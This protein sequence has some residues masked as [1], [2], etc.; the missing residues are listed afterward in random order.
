MEV[1]L[2]ADAE[3]FLWLNG[4]VGTSPIFDRLVQ[5]VVSDYLIPVVFSVV[6]L[7]L[8]FGWAD[9]AMRERH[10]RGVMLAG[11]GVGIASAMV[12]ISNMV[13]FRPRPFDSI[14]VELLFYPPTDSS[15]PANPVAITV[16][17][18]AGVW[19]ANKRMG[20]IMYIVAFVYGCSRVYSGV[21]YPLDI[22]GGALIG[23]SASYLVYFVLKRIEPV[24]TLCLRL[25]RFLCVA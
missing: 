13:Y 16:A 11:I 2:Q 4:W 21:F 24:P 20:T 5:W 7:G 9:Q 25:V 15:F 3:V 8:W 22:L 1:V 23:L 17:M 10:Q 14:D 18:A 19:V 12:K 6:L